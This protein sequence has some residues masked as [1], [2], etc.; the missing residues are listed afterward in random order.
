MKSF[1]RR[2]R[3]DQYSLDGQFIRSWSSIKEAANSFGFTAQTISNCLR[4]KISS[5]HGYKWKYFVAEDL[6]NEIWKAYKD[7]NYLISNMGRVRTK[8]GKVSDTKTRKCGYRRIRLTKQS[9]AVHRMVAE[10]FVPNPENKP[11]V[12]H[13]N[14]IKDD[15]RSENLEWVTHRENM[16]HA[17]TLYQ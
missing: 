16:I 13:I 3:I 17:E 14:G 7:T 4:S 15:N 8:T 1:G 6:E 10:M 2:T 12:N 11:Y 5:A 9:I